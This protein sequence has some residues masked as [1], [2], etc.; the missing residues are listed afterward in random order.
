MGE[1]LEGQRGH[2]TVKEA[3]FTCRWGVGPCEKDGAGARVLPLPPTPPPLQ[4]TSEDPQRASLQPQPP[5]LEVPDEGGEAA[6]TTTQGEKQIFYSRY[7]SWPGPNPIAIIFSSF[8]AREDHSLIR[9][10]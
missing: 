10:C 3:S 5:T 6:Q 4:H 2:S 7:F 8:Y 1:G 9:L